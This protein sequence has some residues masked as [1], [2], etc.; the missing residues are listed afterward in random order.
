MDTEMI[1]LIN[2]RYNKVLEGLSKKDISK[3]QKIF[4]IRLKDEYEQEF[5]EILDR[6]AH[7]VV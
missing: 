5:G 4:L 7:Y 1:V 2:S 6:M 3:E